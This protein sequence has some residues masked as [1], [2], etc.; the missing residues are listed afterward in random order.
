M[1][2]IPLKMFNLL[3]N[4]R[5]YFNLAC[6][7]FLAAS[8]SSAILTASSFA[9][10]L[11]ILFLRLLIASLDIES[12][13]TGRIV[14]ELSPQAILSASNQSAFESNQRARTSCHDR[15][16]RLQRSSYR[17]EP[18]RD[19]LGDPRVHGATNQM[20]AAWFGGGSNCEI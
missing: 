15:R 1:Q 4:D 9:L 3:R 6:F 7:V 10:F 13:P 16:R 20:L 2:I 18:F 14:A 8:F 11:L 5:K 17:L 19:A 12:F